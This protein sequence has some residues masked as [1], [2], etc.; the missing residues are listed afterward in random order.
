MT[1]TAEK[2]CVVSSSITDTPTEEEAL[3][4]DFWAA[5][6]NLVKNL[7]RYSPQEEAPTT[8]WTMARFIA[9]SAGLVLDPL[10]PTLSALF[11]RY[12]ELKHALILRNYRLACYIARRYQ[13]SSPAVPLS[14]LVQEA[15]CGLIVA[16][17][18]F[19]ITR[20]RQLAAYARYWMHQVLQHAIGRQGYAVRLSPSNLRIAYGAL[21]ASDVAD[22]SQRA[23]AVLTAFRG[24]L[25]LDRPARAHEGHTLGT[26]LVD[27]RL[28]RPEARDAKEMVVRLLAQ[29]RPRER[30]VIAL[31]YGLAGQGC[32]SIRRA[33][34]RL[35]V[36]KERAR[37][38]EVRAMKKLKALAQEAGWTAELLHG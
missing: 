5:K 11:H 30:R 27:S 13:A 17:D 3:L 4:A 7:L 16:L 8:P 1:P 31:R 37:Q 6:T 36:S 34:V 15:V 12:T 22:L 18:R 26:S 29:L 23:R 2:C 25:S 14:D 38:L 20:G 32:M 35:H 24:N 28:P 19:N 10:R 33:A 9:N 21:Q